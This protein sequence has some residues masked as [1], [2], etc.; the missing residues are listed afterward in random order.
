LVTYTSFVTKVYF[1][2]KLI[3]WFVSDVTPNDFKETLTSLLKPSFFSSFS[4]VSRLQ[5]W[6]HLEKLA[7][8][9][10]AYVDSG[11]FNLSVPLDTPLGGNASSAEFWHSPFPFWN[12]EVIA[13]E[14]FTMLKHSDLVIFKVWFFMYRIYEL[15]S[16]LT[17]A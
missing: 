10:K 2:P 8:R 12:M 7:T 3:P 17:N 14:V 1:H 15:E 16:R 5:G 13:P 6:G 4:D 9:W 11:V